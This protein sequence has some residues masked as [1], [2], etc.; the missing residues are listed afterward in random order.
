MERGI[1][2]DFEER[3]EELLEY[4]ERGSLKVVVYPGL[5]RS[6]YLADS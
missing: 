6:L 4:P 1:L 5:Y 3:L 2:S